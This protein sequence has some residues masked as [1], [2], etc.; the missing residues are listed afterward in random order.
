HAALQ[1]ETENWLEASERERSDADRDDQHDRDH[2]HPQSAAALHAN[3]WPF[4]NS[5]KR[6]LIASAA[7]RH[8]CILPRKISKYSMTWLIWVSI[9]SSRL[10]V[11]ASEFT[12]RKLCS[13]A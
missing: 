2:R 13:T 7:C 3:S 5:W 11:R 4:A 8:I 12:R 10:T 6:A 1:I 9:V